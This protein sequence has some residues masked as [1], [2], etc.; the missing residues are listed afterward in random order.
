MSR[1]TLI[2]KKFRNAAASADALKL[3]VRDRWEEEPCGIGYAGTPR[4]LGRF[5]RDRFDPYLLIAGHKSR[6]LSVPRGSMGP[7]YHGGARAGA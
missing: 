5:L 4:R 3:R 2:I 7:A 1:S 6:E